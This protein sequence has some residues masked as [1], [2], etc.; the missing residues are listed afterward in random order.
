MSLKTAVPL[1][2]L[3]Q[4]LVLGLDDQGGTADW[5]LGDEDKRLC[6]KGGSWESRPDTGKQGPLPGIHP[7]GRR[8]RANSTARYTCINQ[9]T[10]RLKL[11]QCCASIVS[12]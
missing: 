5:H 4:A 11:T 2:P 1:K 7:G 6:H 12:Q 9:H 10:V 3:Q 8:G